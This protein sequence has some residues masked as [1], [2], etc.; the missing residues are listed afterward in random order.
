MKHTID[1]AIRELSINI[2]PTVSGGVLEACNIALD[3][4]MELKEKEQKTGK[5]IRKK[6]VYRGG[7]VECSVCG[8]PYKC[9]DP[10]KMKTC[11]VC[12]TR[13]EADNG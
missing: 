9:I 13:M 10:K 11:M 12:H 1:D 5:W 7:Y 3:V 2:D 6:D 4:L 8:T